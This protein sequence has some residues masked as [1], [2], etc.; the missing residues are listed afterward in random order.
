MIRGICHGLLSVGSQE[1]CLI[2]FK[3]GGKSDPVVLIDGLIASSFSVL[4]GGKGEV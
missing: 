2:H 1:V 3:D 4:K